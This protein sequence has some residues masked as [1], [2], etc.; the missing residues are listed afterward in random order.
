MKNEEDK[1][2]LDSFEKL[3]AWEHAR[4]FAKEIYLITRDFP[5]EEQF[6][7]TN[8]MRRAAVSVPANIA[9][10]FS[11]QTVPDKLHFYTM[12]LGSLTEIQSFLYIATDVGYIRETERQNLYTTSVK[13]H[14]ILTGLIKATRKRML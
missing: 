1:T 9:E 3:D 13:V 8:Q 4:L 11:R 10:G 5:K 7:I 6:G 12:A 14:K 2:K